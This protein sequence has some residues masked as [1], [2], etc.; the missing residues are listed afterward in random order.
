MS[1]NESKDINDKFQE[2]MNRLVEI[3]DYNFKVINSVSSV[4]FIL[5]GVNLVLSLFGAYGVGSHLFMIIIILL[6]QHLLINHLL[7]EYR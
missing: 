1:E 5:I 3:R 2:D 6:G 4:T 7:K